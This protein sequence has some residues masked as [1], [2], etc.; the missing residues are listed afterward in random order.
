MFCLKE[1]GQSQS[2]V[3]KKKQE[4]TINDD[5]DDNDEYKSS[6]RSR[7]SRSRT[8]SKG[9]SIDQVNVGI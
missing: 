9:P 7:V 8:N 3:D 5:D 2:L 6:D 1:N 4:T